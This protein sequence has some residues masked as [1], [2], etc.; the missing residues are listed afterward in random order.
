PP[1]TAA[2]ARGLP[3]GRAIPL[4]ARATKKKGPSIDEP[5]GDCVPGRPGRSMHPACARAQDQKLCTAPRLN[6][7]LPV[8]VSVAL[9]TVNVLYTSLLMCAKAAYS[10]VR[11]DSGYM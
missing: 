2:S 8:P 4:A 6:A 10:D 11:F 9:P 1:A 7:L 3:E 5:S